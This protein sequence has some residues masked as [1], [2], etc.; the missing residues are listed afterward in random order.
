MGKGI[1]KISKIP[2]FAEKHMREI[3][4]QLFHTNVSYKCFIRHF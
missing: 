3:G 4:E 1:K 2:G